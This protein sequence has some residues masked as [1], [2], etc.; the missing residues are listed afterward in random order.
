MEDPPEGDPYIEYD[1]HQ[2]EE[3]AVEP[4]SLEIWVV[5]TSGPGIQTLT[6]S[7]E[8]G[9]YWLVVMNADA[10]ELVDVEAGLAVKVPILTAIAMGLLFGGIVLVGIGIVVIY[11]GIIR[12][13]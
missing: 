8:E 5:E 11:Y 3:I 4:T 12:P 13:R 7:P 2:G 1:Y 6:W 10:S 9:E